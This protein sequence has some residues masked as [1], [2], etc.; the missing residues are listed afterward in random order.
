M[1]NSLLWPLVFAW[2]WPLLGCGK[3]TVEGPRTLARPVTVIELE[4]GAPP[5]SQLFPGIVRPYREVQVPFEVG[6]R[7]QSIID[8]GDEVKGEQVDRDGNVI[9]PATVLAELDPAPFQRALNRAEQRVL[10]AQKEL[11]AQVVQLEV[12]LPAQLASARSSASAAELNAKHA[13]ENVEALEA[14]VDLARTTVERNR[15]LLPSGAVSDIT[16]RQSEAQL[17]AQRA[18]LAQARTL[19]TARE[20]EHDAA[21]SVIAEVEGAIALREAGNEAQEAGIEELNEAVLDARSDLENCSL[22]AP[23]PGRVTAIHVGEGS[24]VAA[25]SPI[26]TLTMMNPVEVVV[27]VS[28]RLSD[29]L[30]VGTDARVFPTGDRA[31]AG[32]EGIAATVF[33]K[34]GVADQQSR[35]FEVGLIMANQRKN[36]R[37]GRNGKPSVP[38]VLPV[39]RNPL[40]EPSMDGLFVVADALGGEAGDHWVLVVDGLTQGSRNAETLKG[41]LKARRVPVIAAADEL[42]IASFSLVAIEGKELLSEGDLLVPMPTRAHESG[43]Y[44]DDNS[45]L[46]RPGDLVEVATTHGSLPS[47]MYVPVHAI[48]ERNGSTHVFVVNDDGIA[49]EVAVAVHESVGEMRRVAADQSLAGKRIVSGGV[50]FLQDGDRVTITGVT[51]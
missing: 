10:S 36:E 16:V 24:F 51:R 34:R 26:V 49:S 48:R 19:V 11:E 37:K 23:F 9:Q 40:R 44:V 5:P 45:W 6:G 33:E 29:E 25:G 35:T 7:I 21:V 50:H 39:F 3:E 38:Y 22:R 42:K 4:E 43:F 14:A 2:V 32:Q 13:K 8:V 30:V 46:L 1:K 41:E 17:E 47:G 28:G 18:Q 20:K 27:S 15:E 12:V 31:V